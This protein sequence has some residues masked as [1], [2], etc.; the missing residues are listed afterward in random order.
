VTGFD[1]EARHVTAAQPGGRLL[2]LSYDSLIA[3]EGA[4]Q[5]Y[6]GH[7]EYAEW[8]PGMKTLAD[9]LDHRARIWR[10]PAAYAGPNISRWI[11]GGMHEELD[12]TNDSA[13]RSVQKFSALFEK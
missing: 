12:I 9:A 5:S 11:S 6:F 13:A 2:N 8:A 7:D 10:D 4:G 3:A 1:L